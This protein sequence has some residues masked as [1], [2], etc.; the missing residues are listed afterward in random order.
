MLSCWLVFS[1]S[2]LQ[3]CVSWRDVMDSSHFQ[4]SYC[5]HVG[6]SGGPL[7]QERRCCGEKAGRGPPQL[8]TGAVSQLCDPRESNKACEQCCWHPVWHPALYIVLHQ[9]ICVVPGTTGYGSCQKELHRWKKIPWLLSG[10]KCDRAFLFKL[11]VSC[12]EAFH[13]LRVAA[14]MRKCMGHKLQPER[15]TASL[16]H[17]AGAKALARTERLIYVSLGQNSDQVW[18]L[19]C[20]SKLPHC[21]ISRAGSCLCQCRTGSWKC[22]QIFPTVTVVT[23]SAWG[24]WYPVTAS[25]VSPWWL[26]I[27]SSA[28]RVARV[29][30]PWSSYIRFQTGLQN[31]DFVGFYFPSPN[32]KCSLQSPY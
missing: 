16:P 30:G 12:T 32:Q 14:L 7:Q 19:R 20:E 26:L 28:G 25:C 18:F 2:F 27:L 4:L 13:V 5:S 17:P 8:H 21:H 15:V 24:M 31:N 6:C 1:H 23:I 22:S 29:W 10:F 11:W 9:N 3:T